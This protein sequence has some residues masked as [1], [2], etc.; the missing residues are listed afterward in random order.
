MNAEQVF[1]SIRDRCNPR[2]F[3]D[4]VLIFDMFF[5]GAF[6][7][8]ESNFLGGCGDKRRTMHEQMFSMMFPDLKAQVAFGT[9][10]NGL[11][12]FG[13]KRYIADFYDE[14][15]RVIYEIDG[16]S[17]K[18]E[19]DSLKDKIRDWFFWHIKGIKTVRLTNRQVEDMLLTH[20]RQLEKNGK[21]QEILSRP[22]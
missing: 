5:G 20:L 18:Q 10:K 15:K 16:A 6:S 19:I 8:E 7:K 22:E 12:E 1:L 9:G 17:H 11:K 21:L 14:E 2:H 4:F 3:S 13:T